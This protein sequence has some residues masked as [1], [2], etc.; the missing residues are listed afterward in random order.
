MAGIAF[1]GMFV[2]AGLLWA[3]ITRDEDGVIRF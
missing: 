2:A 3:V 1:I